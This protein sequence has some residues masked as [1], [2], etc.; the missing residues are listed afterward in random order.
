MRRLTRIAPILI[1]AAL[2]GCA[3]TGP[4]TESDRRVDIDSH[5]LLGD[6]ALDR[7]QYQ[8]ALEHYLQAALLSDDAALA[9]RAAMLAYRLDLPDPGV[10]A[11]RRWHE[12]A[13][14]DERAGQFLGVLE[15]RSDQ[16]EQALADFAAAVR[17]AQDRGD[18]LAAIGELLANEHDPSTAES[19]M[20]GLVEQFPE[21]TAG[22]FGLARL[23]LR[24]GDFDTALEHART[25]AD[26]EPDSVDIQLLYARALLLAGRSADSL[27]LAAQLAE[28]HP[29]VEVR[30]QYAELL[31]SA[32][33]GEEAEQRLND[34]LAEHPALPEAVRALG[35]LALT[36]DE[37]DTAKRQFET[38]RTD[39]HYRNEA[40]YYLGRIA[41][42]QGQFLQA[43]RA[44]ARVT[45][46]THAVE[47]QLRTARILFTEM[48]DREGALRH[49]RE[50][51]DA[52]PRYGSEMLVAQSQILLQME[53]PDA[54]M[55]LLAD[56]IDAHPEDQTLHAAQVQLYIILAQDAIDKQDLDGA[57]HLLDQGLNRYPGNSSIR[58]AQALLY[59]QQGRLRK[60]VNV[61][62]GLVADR[63]DD[64][65]L[66]NALGYLLT[67]QFRRHTEARGY[68]QKALALDPDN[69]A[70]ID[71]MGWVLHKLGQ[72]QAALDY[73]ERA[74]RLEADPEIAAHLI[75]V[76]LALGQEEQ[77]RELLK[78]SLAEHPDS[79]HLQE[80]SHRLEQ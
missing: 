14:D 1:A 79:P 65:A 6:I 23:A 21:P 58:Y 62:E 13:P 55:Q 12:L 33:H 63:P 3:T 38:L 51:G 54:A 28:Q 5:T 2:L 74:Y 71:S 7:E 25:A 20:T 72:Q 10:R 30:L 8:E 80:L 37:L 44:Y 69:P 50:F 26:A 66:L 16:P 68:I 17:G 22:H 45:D 19:V 32:G 73:L 24:A 29:D 4:A 18:A 76:R 70:I 41:Q 49:L 46:G 61:L 48:G 34:I 43:T 60:A 27:A 36:R 53:E 57:E 40:F 52:N 35:F 39:P 42:Q 67:D 59:Q 47:A 31:L 56:A 15:L 9:E 77:A 78:A 75:D 11:A 64:P